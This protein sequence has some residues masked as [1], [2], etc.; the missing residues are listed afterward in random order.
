M[1]ARFEQRS[2]ISSRSSRIDGSNNQTSRIQT[3]RVLQ[4][5]IPMS[6]TPSDAT[7]FR[8]DGFEVNRWLLWRKSDSTRA[9]TLTE[10]GDSRTVKS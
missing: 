5:W 4:Q 1:M 8:V 7:A 10:L 9:W 6:P 3:E 2:T